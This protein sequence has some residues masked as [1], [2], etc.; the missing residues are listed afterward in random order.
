M[1]AVEVRDLTVDFGATR[2]ALDHLSL[3]V[4]DGEAFVVAGPSGGG[5]TTLLR[6]IAGLQ[7]PTSGDVLFDGRSVTSTPVR[8]RD[9]AYVGSRDAL[10]RHLDVEQNLTFPLR[11]RAV[12]AAQRD[13]RVRA[14]SRVLRLTR[15]LHRRPSTLSGGEQQRAALG[16]ATARRP[17]LFLFDE[18]LAYLEPAERHR[19]TD[20]LRT[21]Q[22]GMGVTAIFVTHDQR[23]LMTLGQRLAIVSAG[24]LEQVGPPLELYRQPAT[25]TVATFVGDPPMSLVRADLDVPGGTVTL[26]GTTVPLPPP[27]RT[28]LQ[29][30]PRTVLI[31]L[32]PEH[33]TPHLPGIAPH[34][35]GPRHTSRSIESPATASHGD[36]TRLSLHVALTAPLGFS[37]QVIGD[38]GGRPASRVNV[39]VPA[40]YSVRRGDVLPVSV[41]VDRMHV[42]HAATG[43]ALHP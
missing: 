28:S 40:H 24:R 30:S 3:S 8:D 39:M 5:K 23:E 1:V 34:A 41:A 17:R 11:H 18:P 38:L 10:Y 27:L 31:G 37:Q 19:L 25:T 29:E 9:V 16:R 21:L 32:R 4:A 35:R 42:F 20:D 12:E 33:I 13:E 15:L 2:P 7:D 14:T 22:Q 36:E 6:T 26:A 43:N